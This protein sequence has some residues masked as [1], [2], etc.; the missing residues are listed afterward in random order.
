MEQFC[1][2]VFWLFIFIFFVAHRSRKIGH[3]AL[4]WGF[5]T[6]LIEPLVTIGLVGALPDRTLEKKRHREMELLEAQIVQA[7][8][9]VRDTT[10][11]PRETV[12]DLKTVR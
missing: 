8:L 10:P 4:L 5:V 12:S 6:L 3:S 7:G 9:T 2:A 11:V 1:T